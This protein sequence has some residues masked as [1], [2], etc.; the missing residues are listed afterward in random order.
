MSD[1][2]NID[3]FNLFT[4]ALFDCL[5][6]NFPNPIQLNVARL[7][8]ELLPEEMSNDAHLRRIQLTVHATSFLAE[9]QF[10]TYK[11]ARPTVGQFVGIR[12]TSKGLAVLNSVPD[13][14]DKNEPIIGEIREALAGEAKEAGGESIRRIVQTLLST[15]LASAPSLVSREIS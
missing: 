2:D 11:D 9:E 8:S 1:P 6:T 14:I 12:L 15:G 4:I 5:Y 7:V 10:I 3:F 13:S